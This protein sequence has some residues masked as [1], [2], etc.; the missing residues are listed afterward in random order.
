[1]STNASEERCRLG[2][3]ENVDVPHTVDALGTSS[4]LTIEKKNENGIV[5]VS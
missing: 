3:M 1:V 2:T 5:F 4:G